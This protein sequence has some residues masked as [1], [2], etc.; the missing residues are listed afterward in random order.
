MSTPLSRREVPAAV[1]DEDGGGDALLQ[2]RLQA[3][4]GEEIAGLLRCR[5]ADDDG[6]LAEAGDILHCEHVAGAAHQIEDAL[7]SPERQR[8][9]LGQCDAQGT[10]QAPL[11]HGRGHPGR[12]TMR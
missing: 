6:Q 2:F 12:S 10:G 4:H 8:L 11:D 7:S 3:Q 5:L 1:A 9:G